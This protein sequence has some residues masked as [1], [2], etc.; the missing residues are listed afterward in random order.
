MGRVAPGGGGPGTGLRSLQDLPLGA[1][2]GQGLELG[3][4]PHYTNP[5]LVSEARLGWLPV[6]CGDYLLVIQGIPV[7]LTLRR[8]PET[9]AFSLVRATEERCWERVHVAGEVGPWV[10]LCLRVEQPSP[11]QILAHFQIS[12]KFN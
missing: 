11:W 9:S 4:K 12:F 7:G 6:S 8:P 2:E 5:Q 10:L 3:Q 1:R